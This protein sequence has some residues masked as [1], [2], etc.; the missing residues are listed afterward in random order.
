L[1]LVTVWEV[2]RQPFN[3]FR[4]AAGVAAYAAVCVVGRLLFADSVSGLITPTLLVAIGCAC[5]KLQFRPARLLPTFAAFAAALYAVHFTI[6]IAF[7]PT[8]ALLAGAVLVAVWT[9]TVLILTRL[10]HVFINLFEAPKNG[11]A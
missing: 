9:S 4:T 11:A 5:S 10:E 3:R 7:G 8:R 1:G 6:H 2:G